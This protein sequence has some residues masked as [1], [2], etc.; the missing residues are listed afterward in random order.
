LELAAKYY[1]IALKLARESA[2]NIELN[3][4]ELRQK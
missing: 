1:E 4:E 2:P 3:V